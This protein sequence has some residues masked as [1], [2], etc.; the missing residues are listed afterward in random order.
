[1][2]LPIFCLRN[3]FLLCNKFSLPLLLLALLGIIGL[4]FDII[5][6]L[7]IVGYFL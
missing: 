4:V 7:D 6:V 1:M 5:A 3:Y 2:L